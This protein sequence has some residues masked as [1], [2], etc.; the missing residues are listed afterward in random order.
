MISEQ[1]FMMHDLIT[2]HEKRLF[3]QQEA[4]GMNVRVNPQPALL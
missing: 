1:P 4:L 3:R 2:A